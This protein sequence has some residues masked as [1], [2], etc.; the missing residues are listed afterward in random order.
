MGTDSPS[1]GD[2]ERRESIIEVLDELIFHLNTTRGIFTLL[3][4]SSLI[5]A[6][7]SLV[8]GFVF[9]GHPRFLMF[10]LHRLPD[11]GVMILVYV[12]IS[13]AFSSIWLFIGVKELRFFSQW[14]MRFRKFL[15][16]KEQ[17]DK[18]LGE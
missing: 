18:E 15:S 13:I 10:L 7:I 5:L 14:N 16:L 3:I 12:I 2:T 11:V 17:I 9:I 1:S 6:P 8:M 4:V